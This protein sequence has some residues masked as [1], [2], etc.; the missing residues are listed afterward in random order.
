MC[1]WHTSA[2]M[3][4][5]YWQG[6]SGRQGPMNTLAPTYT[7]NT[8]LFPQSFIT[9]AK[10]VGLNALGSSNTWTNMELFRA[11]RD[12]GPIWCA[13]YWYGAGHVIVLTGIDGGTVYINDPD[14]AT[15]KTGTLAWFN[16]KLASS[17]VGCMQVKDP[18]A[19]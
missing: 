8:G 5:L 3:V 7:G 6:Q 10:T 17:L 19:Y 4:W 2:M 13:G 18:K 1:C 9:L 12:N 16:E 15:A 11:L 14:R